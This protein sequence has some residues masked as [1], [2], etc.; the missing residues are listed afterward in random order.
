MVLFQAISEIE[1]PLLDFG[2]A[3]DLNEGF[4]IEELY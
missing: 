2:S 3:E 4:R 1:S